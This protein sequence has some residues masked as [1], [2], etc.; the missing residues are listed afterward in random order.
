[1]VSKNKSQRLGLFTERDIQFLYNKNKEKTYSNE[2]IR[3]N[4]ERIVKKAQQS[5]QDLNIAII[6]LPENHRQKIDFLLGLR[7][8]QKA[9][10]RYAKSNER[11]DLVLENTIDNLD[12]C[13]A[14]IRKNTSDK[15]SNIAENDFVN[16]KAWINAFQKYPK[17]IGV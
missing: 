16:V 11:P 6:H 5:F 14:I 13:L 17:S 15:I 9:L 10:N 4:Y 1:M 12:E 3:K 7:G 2:A 8:I